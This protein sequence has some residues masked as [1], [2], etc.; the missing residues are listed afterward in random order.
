M[1]RY[2]RVKVT[3]FMWEE[4]AILKSEGDG[5]RA[6]SSLWNKVPLGSEYISD[7]IIEHPDNRDLL[8]EVWPIGKLEKM[9]FGDKKQAQAAAAALYKGD[10]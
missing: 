4:G 8:Q 6:I 9:V 3:N 7:R 10:K 1:A 5:Y 2:F